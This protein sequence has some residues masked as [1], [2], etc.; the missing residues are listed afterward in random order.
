MGAKVTLAMRE[1]QQGLD[2]SMFEGVKF[3]YHSKI[4]CLSSPSENLAYEELMQKICDHTN[5]QY[6][7]LDGQGVTKSWFEGNLTAHVEFIEIL[8]QESLASKIVS[9]GYPTHNAQPDD[10]IGRSVVPPPRAAD[11]LD[12]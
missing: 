5:T 12:Y 1:A 9:E 4:F 6:F 7:V 11:F 8:P 3:K 10:N 2:E